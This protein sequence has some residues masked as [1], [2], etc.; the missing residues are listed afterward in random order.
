MQVQS[1]SASANLMFESSCKLCGA[2]LL[3]GG[4]NL[5]LTFLIE[6]KIKKKKNLVVLIFG[7]PV[8]F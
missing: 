1:A 7:W 3:F 8:I 6:N 4:L 2:W 5:L